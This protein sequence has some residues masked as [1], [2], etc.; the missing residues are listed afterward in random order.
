M[1]DRHECTVHL[2]RGQFA[3]HRVAQRKMRQRPVITCHEG[4][5]GLVPQGGDL[6]IGEQPILQ[7][8]LAAQLIAPV[9]QRHIV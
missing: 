1:A 4:V 6:F 2:Q 3:S 8:L 5:H 9:N 7:N